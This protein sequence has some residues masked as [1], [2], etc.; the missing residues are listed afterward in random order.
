MDYKLLGRSGV[1]VSPLILGG[2]NFGGP[3]RKRNPLDH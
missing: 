3:T 1:K 2:F